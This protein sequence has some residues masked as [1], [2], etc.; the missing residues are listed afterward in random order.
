MLSGRIQSSVLVIYYRHPQRSPIDCVGFPIHAI[1]IILVKIHQSA[2]SHSYDQYARAIDSIALQSIAR[3][4]V[5][6]R[7]CQIY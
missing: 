1:W 7:R 3:S 2:S 6:V 5:V 4:H